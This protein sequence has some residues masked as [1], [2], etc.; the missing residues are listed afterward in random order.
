MKGQVDQAKMIVV[1]WL[2]K[3]LQ[4]VAVAHVK[5]DFSSPENI[6]NETQALLHTCSYRTHPKIRPPY[7]NRLCLQN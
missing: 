2:V 6:L 4:G 7:F 5:L 3:V 1:C